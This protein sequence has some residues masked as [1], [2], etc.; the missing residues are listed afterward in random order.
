MASGRDWGVAA[1]TAAVLALGTATEALAQGW[2]I[3]RRPT[4]PIQRSFEV[5][6]LTVDARIRDQAAEVQVSQTFYNP[7]SSDL[8]SEYYF[9]IPEDAVVENLVLM[10]DGKEL[11]GRLLGKEGTS[12]L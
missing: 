5:R 11:P 10:V 4:I 8:E 6:E 7:G 12:H 3:D 9:P 2:I 1:L